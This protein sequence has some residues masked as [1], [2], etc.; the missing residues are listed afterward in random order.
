MSQFIMLQDEM[1]SFPLIQQIIT[2]LQGQINTLRVGSDGVQRSTPARKK[3]LT[4]ALSLVT[5]LR[6]RTRKTLK[7]KGFK[8][9][10]EVGNTLEALLVEALG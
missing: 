5:L 9:T 1:K 2:D 10:T 4:K 7:A 3:L 8:T 6:S